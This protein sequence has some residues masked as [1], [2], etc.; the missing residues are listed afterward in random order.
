MSWLRQK[1]SPEKRLTNWVCLMNVKLLNRE[2][3]ILK[4]LKCPVGVML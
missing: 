3:L 4:Q 2:L 1:K